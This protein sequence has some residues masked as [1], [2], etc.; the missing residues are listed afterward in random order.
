[1]FFSCLE[2][3]AFKENPHRCRVLL[4]T[5]KCSLKR[6]LK[7]AS[8]HK[9]IC[10]HLFPLVLSLSL[11][12]TWCKQTLW[13]AARVKHTATS[14]VGRGP[15]PSGRRSVTP[16]GGPPESSRRTRNQPSPHSTPGRGDTE[17]NYGFEY[18]SEFKQKSKRPLQFTVL[19]TAFVNI[20]TIIIS[21]TYIKGEKK[22][23]CF[24]QTLSAR[25]WV[26]D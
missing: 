1:M 20:M 16:A 8:L 6:Q 14:T 7:I 4:R 10:S 13:S 5:P 17:S 3:F 2:S 18:S 9:I 11:H 26:W 12:S 23:V 25:L 21:T 19:Y 24:S 22:K 15:P